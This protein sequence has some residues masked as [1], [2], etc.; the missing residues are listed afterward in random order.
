MVNIIKN[1]GP[2]DNNNIVGQFPVGGGAT[3]DYA[4]VSMAGCALLHA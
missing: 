2:L 3:S 4:D 1:R